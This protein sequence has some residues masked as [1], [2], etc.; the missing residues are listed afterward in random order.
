MNSDLRLLRLLHGELPADE[1]QSLQGRMAEDRE[2]AARYEVLRKSWLTLELPEPAAA[3]PGF[4][5]RVATRARAAQEELSWAVAPL[6]VRTAA[7][8]A[9]VVGVVIGA[10]LSWS[11]GNDASNGPAGMYESYLTMVSDAGAATEPASPA[12]P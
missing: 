10:S 9:L 2:L 11:T 7:A 8:A 3:P 12:N 4:A 6:W 5:A 1:A